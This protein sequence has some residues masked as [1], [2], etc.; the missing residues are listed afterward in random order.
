MS[1][2]VEIIDPY[3]LMEAY[4]EGYFPM[5]KQESETEVEWY[6]AKKRGIMPLEG[7]HIPRRVLRRI[8]SKGYYPRIN[9]SFSEVIEGCANRESTW[10]NSTIYNSF[11]HAHMMGFAHSMEVWRDNSLCGGLYGIAYGG[12]F[13]AESIF[14]SEPECMKI[15]LH[16]CH[17][18]LIERGFTLWDVQFYNPFLGQFGC[19]EISEK[20]YQT[21]LNEAIRLHGCRFGTT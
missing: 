15:A 4:A 14:Q 2:S 20:A 9:A 5:G 10:I 7:V 13:F 16:F 18:H 6:S 8:R 19:K 11:L 1:K 12:A 21:L 3:F 17:Q